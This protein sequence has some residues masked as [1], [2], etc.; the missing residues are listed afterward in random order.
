MRVGTG[1]ILS[2]LSSS[3]L[4]AVI[5]NYDSH[6][7]LLARRAVNPENRDLLWKR[8][9]GKQTGA[10][11]GTGIGEDSSSSSSS[12]SGLSKMSRLQEFSE[13]L[14][15]SFMKNRDPRKQQYILEKEERSLQNAAKKLAEVTDGISKDQFVIE[16]KK[17]LTIALEGVKSSLKLYETKPITLFLLSIPEDKNRKSLTKRMVKIQNTAKKHTNQHLKAITQAINNIAKHPRNVINEMEKITRSAS[18]ISLEL[19]NLYNGDYT[20]LASKVKSTGNEENIEVTK[21]Y[22]SEVDDHRDSAFESLKLI[23]GEVTS[24]R[25]TFKGKN[26]SRFGAFRSGVKK[27]LGLKGKSSTDVTPNSEESGQQISGEGPSDE[28]TSDQEESKQGPPDENTSGQGPPGQGPPGQ[29]APN[30]AGARPIPA[31]RKSK[32]NRQDLVV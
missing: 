24:G 4:A 3:V 5:P 30:Q 17:F 10:G 27:R 13:E 6:G 15:M 21:D 25:V 29:Q 9:N 7:I 22:I 1:V 32:F 31:P 28:N 26:T 20:A 2:V 8:N 23:K 19:R 16:V 14:R 12:S 18:R 11:T